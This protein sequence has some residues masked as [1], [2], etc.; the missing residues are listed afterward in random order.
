[1]VLDSMIG[2]IAPHRCIGCGTYGSVMCNACVDAFGEQVQPRCAGCKKLMDD[3]KT[4]TSCRAWLVLS[5]VYVATHYDGVGEKLIHELKYSTKRQTAYP[6][7]QLMSEVVPLQVS[8][9][10]ILCPVPTAPN[11]VRERGFDHAVVIARFLSQRKNIPMSRVLQ[12]ITN[13]RQVGATR[14][15]RLRQM[16]HAFTV[17]QNKVKDKSVLL[18]DDVFTTGATL[19]AATEA[20][21]KAG[22]KKVSAVV[23]CQK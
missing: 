12:R 19:I 14:S 20:L 5:N 13:T 9:D 2:L 21:R 23:F 3:F 17:D 7:A 8:N 4:C 16:E 1:M 15:E 10:T 22:A 18:V 6:I 11:R